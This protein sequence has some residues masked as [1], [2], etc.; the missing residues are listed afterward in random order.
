MKET[1]VK[2]IVINMKT[3]QNPAQFHEI[4]A[5]ELSFP[6]YY[7]RNL[8]AL[9]DLLSVYPEALSITLVTDGSPETEDGWKANVRRVLM[10]ACAVNI[11][12]LYREQR[13]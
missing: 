12:M 4:L 10:D 13:T 8:D 1:A 7:G 6:E 11:H 3:I 9:Y 2:E 5:K